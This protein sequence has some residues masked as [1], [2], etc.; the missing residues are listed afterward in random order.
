[1]PVFPA[2]KIS[3]EDLQELA[4]FIAAM[5]GGHAQA[6]AG[7][8]GDDLLMHHWMALSAIETNDIIEAS[9][10]VAHILDGAEGQHLR[11]MEQ[12]KT[13]LFDGEIHGAAHI[14]EEMLAGLDAGEV[15]GPEMYMRLALSSLRADD[16]TNATHHV[17]H[18]AA[19]SPGDHESAELVHEALL[20]RDIHEA[21]EMMLALL[22]DT[23]M[24]D[25][26]GGDAHDATEADTHEDG[27]AHEAT[28]ADVH[29][30]SDAH[31]AEG[32]E[33][34]TVDEEAHPD[35]GHDH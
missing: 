5:D 24:L 34:E 25:E 31:E 17:E 33:H 9:H 30:D 6:R 16:L 32:H 23:G 14:I 20:S 21:E 22:G 13:L 19:S 11:M 12:T 8:S 35:D 10:H 18:Y 26:H 28:E 2:D 29:K 7:T 3:N 1:M 4:E 15:R 27:D